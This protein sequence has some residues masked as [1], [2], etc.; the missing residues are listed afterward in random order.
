MISQSFLRTMLCGGRRLAGHELLYI[1]YSFRGLL[2]S[3]FR[4]FV[5]R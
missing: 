1:H 2:T 5:N 4:A 3:A